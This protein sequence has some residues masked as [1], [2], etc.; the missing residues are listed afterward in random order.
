[1]R[2]AYSALMILV[3]ASAVPS[4]GEAQVLNPFGDPGKHDRARLDHV[5]PVATVSRVGDIVALA[6]A[7]VVQDPSGEPFVLGAATLDVR[8]PSHARIVFTVANATGRPLPLND[9]DVIER[10]MVSSRPDNGRPPVP[11]NELAVRAAPHGQGELQPGASVTIQIPISAPDCR[12]ASACELRGFLVF[13]GRDLTHPDLRTT[14]PSDPAWLEVGLR[15]KAL[16]VRAFGTLL[17]EAHQ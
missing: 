4:V 11:L 17:S 8:D 3:M 7:R 6:D 1:M 14:T 12:N 9:L 16:F 13:V 10:T 5:V 15:E 2:V